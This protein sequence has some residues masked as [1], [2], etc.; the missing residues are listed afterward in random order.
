MKRGFTLIELL[1]TVGIIALLAIVVVVVINPAELLKQGRDVT[2]VSDMSTLTKAISLYYQDA[3]SNPNTLFM[4][5]SSLVYVSV[6]DPAATSTAGDQCQGLGLPS[7]PS[8]TIYQCAPSST[9]KKT[10]GT[11]WIPINF[12]SYL[13]GQGGSIIST[14][15]T[16]PKNATSTN[17]Y[18]TY[19]TDG[20]G[21]FKL[22]AYLESQKYSPQM[23]TDGGI[24][25]LTYEK[26]TNLALALGRT[27]GATN[28]SP[29]LASISPN[30]TST[31]G[32][33]FTLTENGSSFVS[34]ATVNWNGSALSTTYVSASQLTATV[35]S[36]DIAIAGSNFVTV[37][38]PTPGGG[39]SGSATFSVTGAS[40]YAY[41]RAITVSANT[42]IASGTESNFPM[43][44]S[45]TLASWEPTSLGGH[46]QN[47]VTA[48]NGG[49]EPADLIYSTS[50]YCTSPLSFETESYV[51]STGALVDWVKVPS[52]AASQVIYACYGNSSVT[53]DQSHPSSTW[54]STYAGVWHV[55]NPTSSVSTYDSV[56]GGGGTNNGPVETSTGQI[57]GAGIWGTHSTDGITT[58]LNSSSTQRSY[59]IWF[60]AS[61]GG[62]GSLGRLWDKRV[63][64]AQIDEAYFGNDSSIIGIVYAPTWSGGAAGWV[65][66]N[67]G[68]GGP[69]LNTWYYLTITYN[70]SSVSNAPI[71]Y[72]NGV[73]TSTSVAISPSG[74]P[75]Y[76]TDDYVIGN[77]ANDYAR[78]WQ[79]KLD[80]FEIA[81][82]IFTPSW[83]LTQYNNQNSPSTF[84]SVGSEGTPN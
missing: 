84:Y 71:F 7:A 80:E 26:G 27:F 81:N 12:N 36:G 83:V 9:Y 73:A 34:G 19:T 51:S 18:Y 3:M 21:G 45:S 52:L 23:T 55:A 50:S 60:N 56:T 59:S 4:G 47:L 46:I 14:L 39:T 29:T 63:S 79:G 28:P 32:G 1:V 65:W 76:N 53:T 25:P 74:S 67:G 13:S 75:T 54:N 6:P 10:D 78:N 31:G 57:D 49:T 61:G 38:N 20:I 30:A 2:R 17:F 64:G 40:G 16:D 62:G 69:T 8:G 77:R 15:P 48:P 35:P 33:T 44:V 58:D 41:D 68:T 37:T 70:N 42:N 24:D 82:T 5:T 72:I 22:A 11:G 66:T 43:L